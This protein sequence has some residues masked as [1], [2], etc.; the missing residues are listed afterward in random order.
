MYNT[1][2]NVKKGSNLTTYAFLCQ[3]E[4]WQRRHQGSMPETVFVQI[5]GGSENENVTLKAACELVCLKRIVKTI[6]LTRLPTGHTHE[7]I[8]A[9]FGHIWKWMRGTPIETLDDYCYGIQEAFE[10][11]K[12]KVK[13]KFIYMIPD[14]VKFFQRYIDPEFGNCARM[15]STQHC[16]LFQAVESSI[17]FPLGV[18]TLYK[19]YSSDKVVQLCKMNPASCHTS[20]GQLTGLEPITTICN[21][22]HPSRDNHLK[23]REGIEGFYILKSVPFV[24]DFEAADFDD[25]GIKMFHKCYHRIKEFYVDPESEIRSWWDSW[26][27]NFVPKLDV[28]TYRINHRLHVPLRQYL[29]DIN[30]KYRPKWLLSSLSETNRE[31]FTWPSHHVYCLPSV[32][33]LWSRDA[34]PCRSNILTTDTEVQNKMDEFSETCKEYYTDLKNNVSLKVIYETI[35][36]SRIDNKGKFMEDLYMYFILL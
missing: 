31:G 4:D 24:E 5:D 22:W 20:I 32:T 2:N 15:E 11:T 25:Q 12:L 19:A 26:Y 7:D 30:I 28:E 1:F 35:I 34:G 23:G 36:R 17:M 16:W 13:V 3:L 10:S 14:Y 21:I 8:D 27:E 9:V 18:K 6:Y 33:S 29:S